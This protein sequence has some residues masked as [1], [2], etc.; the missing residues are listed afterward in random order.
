MFTERQVSVI[1]GNISDIY[2]IAKDFLDS[3]EMTVSPCQSVHLALV[4]KCFL[5]HV[6]ISGFKVV[7]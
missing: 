6:S 5:Q 3:L 4:G 2:E 1:F 7:K